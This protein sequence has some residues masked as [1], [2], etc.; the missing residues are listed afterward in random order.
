M[1][2]I[3]ILFA[4]ASLALL[5]SLAS[6]LL[7]SAF[8]GYLLRVDIPRLIALDALFLF[9]PVFL[10]LSGFAL[11]KRRSARES[12]IRHLPL[13]ST[14]FAAFTPIAAVHL[15]RSF[16]WQTIG[17][18]A[19]LFLLLMLI[20]MRE[21]RR[22]GLLSREKAAVLALVSLIVIGASIY[23]PLPG[24][25]DIEKSVAASAQPATADAPNLLLIV[26]DTTRADHLGLYGYG[27]NTSP[28][29][30]A[31]AAQST[32]FDR[33]I[34]SS[35]YTLPTHATLFTGLYPKSHG[36]DLSDRGGISLGQFGLLKHW[37]SVLPL[38]QDAETL[39]ERAKAA[40]MET[41]AICGNTAYLARPFALDQGFDTYVDAKGSDLDWRPAGLSIAYK[42]LS[43]KAWRLKRLIWGNE[44]YYRL[45]SEV[46]ELALQW[47]E[48]R[49]DRRFFLFLNYMEPHDPYLP[50]G[51][52][53]GAYPQAYSRQSFERKCSVESK[54]ELLPHEQAPLIDAYDAE[55]RSMDDH[56]RA[57]FSQLQS[58]GLL[59]T[60]LVV[61]IGDHGESFGDHGRHSHCTSVYEPQVWV[62]LIYREPGQMQ[63]ERIGRLV[64]MADVFPTICE[65]IGLKTPDEVQGSSLFGAGRGMPI[66]S[67]LGRYARDF[68]ENAI[69]FNDWK[70]IVRSDGKSELYKLR[71][72]ALELRNVAAEHPSQVLALSL[73]LDWFRGRAKPLFNQVP[74]SV[75]EDVIQRLKGVGYL[76]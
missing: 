27:R 60:T 15:W 51:R 42:L 21:F 25:S 40:G 18:C 53:R 11:L 68:T 65:S 38:P 10:I 45:G 54:R 61:F 55:I 19:V 22:G 34:A 71:E 56:L 16:S 39:A 17:I 62:P 58:W 57:L 69:Y 31:F 30:D 46:N 23:W 76:R 50:V 74:L 44:K 43:E 48:P 66:V 35:S 13:A 8:N 4:L 63:G 24:S 9:F 49:R 47:L 14:L 67:S 64:H 52:Y 32:V 28:W 20:A 75:N 1:R 36:A 41:G 29:L 59:D 26:L 7:L 73:A 33:A 72:D 5:I 37:Q 2:R 12:M 6:D 3:R 70:L